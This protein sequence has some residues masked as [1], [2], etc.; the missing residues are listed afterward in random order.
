MSSDGVG[1][2]RQL[3]N[4]CKPCRAA[5]HREHYLANKQRCVDQARRRKLA[6]AEINMC[7]LVLFLRNRSCVDCGETDVMVLESDHL[8]DKLFNISRA[9]PTE[10]G[11][12]SKPRSRSAMSCARTVIGAGPL[13]VAGSCVP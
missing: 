3:D 9:L 7:A 6:L 11:P 2:G 5:F 1:Q 10:G 12:T 8:A 13:P 4:Y